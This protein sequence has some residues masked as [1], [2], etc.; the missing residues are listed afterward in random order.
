M[1]YSE[2]IIDIR[3]T[4][5]VRDGMYALIRLRASGLSITLNGIRCYLSGSFL[6]CLSKAD[7]LTVQ[8]G[9]H[10][11]TSIHF[12]PYFYNVNLNHEVIG[13]ALYEEMRTRH[14]YPDF[15]LFRE[16]NER[17]F[18]I[19]PLTDYEYEMILACFRRAAAHLEGHESDVMWSCRTR[20]DIISVLRIGEGAYL[21]ERTG[22]K[23]NE[24][25]RYIRDHVG[26]PI[27]LPGL[28]K[29]FHTNRTTLS[30]LIKQMTGLSPM[31]YIIE[32][33]L[34]QSC[35]D[36]LFTRI[37]IVE[38]AHKYGF[39][40][41]NYYIRAFK[42]RFGTT[43]LRYRNDG[44]AERLKNEHIYHELARAQLSAPSEEKEDGM[45]SEESASEK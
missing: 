2:N 29:Q 3:P 12:L 19:L 34:N 26:E 45:L 25:L 36:L 23:G 10:D 1:E 24:I 18:G 11:A 42:K 43:P 4:L 27:T 28:C 21:G 38:V 40:D 32:E 33:R 16:R 44:Y 6:L 35:P 15:H 8:G 37:P 14:G 30:A 31:Q 22:G 20:S 13:L 17:Y 41:V 7:V 39:S 5:S 9:K